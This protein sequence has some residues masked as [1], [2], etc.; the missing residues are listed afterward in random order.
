MNQR[1]SLLSI[2]LDLISS[3][4]KKKKPV[5]TRITYRAM[6]TI[7]QDK[8]ISISAPRKDKNGYYIKCTLNEKTLGEFTALVRQR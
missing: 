4:S 3:S 2:H 1:E 6:L 5:Q 8:L 7:F